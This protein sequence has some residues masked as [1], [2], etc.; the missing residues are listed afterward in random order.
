MFAILPSPSGRG[1]REA[2]GEGLNLDVGSDL[3]S[4]A[5]KINYRRPSGDD[6]FHLQKGGAQK[7]DT[8]ELFQ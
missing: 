2:P 1:R 4:P 3:P 6:T 8:F 7:C 5:L